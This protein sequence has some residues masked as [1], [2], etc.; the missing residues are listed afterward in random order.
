MY[1]V[2][3][4]N[5][6]SF[7]DLGMILTS[8]DIPLPEPKIHTIEIPC[9]DGVID[10]ST[11]LTDGIMK[12]KNREITMNFTVDTSVSSFE[13]VKS[14]ISNH[15]HGKTLKV[16][17]DVDPDFFY[18]G[19]CTVDDIN[20]TKYPATVSIYVDAKPYKYKNTET[21]VTDTVTST[22]KT[23]TLTNGAMPVTPTI[24]V[25]SETTIVFNGD[26]FSINAGTHKVLGLTLTEGD[27]ELSV[28]GS[29]SVV[30]KYTEG[31]L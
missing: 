17:F 28:K 30:F 26:T 27:N 13:E 1:G 31:S 12:Y 4:G 19:R 18:W 11:A 16:V 15:L 24:T 8:R 14:I 7:D 2:T 10:V 25:T 22:P 23:I 9:A 3:F 6:H 20:T 5:K 21:V 29:G